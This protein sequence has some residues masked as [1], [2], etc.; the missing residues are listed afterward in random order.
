MPRWVHFI[1]LKWKRN[2]EN[3][4]FTALA[5][6]RKCA[7]RFCIYFT[8]CNFYIKNGNRVLNQLFR[9]NFKWIRT[10]RFMLFRKSSFG[11][12]LSRSFSCL[13]GEHLLRFSMR[14]LLFMLYRALDGANKV[15][16]I[17]LLF[18]RTVIGAIAADG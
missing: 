4:A 13:L 8:S 6:T 1:I 9:N 15:Q 16:F 11:F 5:T 3:F 17:L 18:H 10:N 14:K 12:S 2:D 7:R